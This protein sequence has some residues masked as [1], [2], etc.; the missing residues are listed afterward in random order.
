M[1]DDDDDDDRLKEE[2]E[3]GEE[4]GGRLHCLFTHSFIIVASRISHASPVI[5]TLGFK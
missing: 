4:G 1:D 3:E 2:R 5:M